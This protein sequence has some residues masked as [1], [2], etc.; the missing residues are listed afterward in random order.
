MSE[1]LRSEQGVRAPDEIGESDST[2]ESRDARRKRSQI[3]A[4]ITGYI[5]VGCKCPKRGTWE[6]HTEGNGFVGAGAKPTTLS[7][8][9]VD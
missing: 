6:E 5:I 8:E 4:V 3:E 2:E 9:E 1:S 7:R